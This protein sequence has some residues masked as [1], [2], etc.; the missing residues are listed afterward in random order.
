MNPSHFSQPLQTSSTLTKNIEQPQKTEHCFYYRVGDFAILLEKSLTTEVFL[1]LSV[2]AIPFSPNWCK[3]L[4]NLR[5]DLLPVVDLHQLLMKKSVNQHHFLYLKHP[6]FPAVILSC[7]GYPQPIEL[8]PQN[9]SSKA[10]LNTPQWLAQHQ[11][12][13]GKGLFIANHGLLLKILQQQHQT[14]I[15]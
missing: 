6:N 7:D 5:S 9:K 15:N 2:T 10:S 4:T 12:S 13:L 11:Q 14:M 1:N 3:G 8:D